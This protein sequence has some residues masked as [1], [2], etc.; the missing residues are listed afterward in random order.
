MLM[1]TNQKSWTVS[2]MNMRVGAAAGAALITQRPLMWKS[3]DTLTTG[4]GGASWKVV[5]SCNG[6]GGA[7]SFT[8][9][10]SPWSAT[11]SKWT[12]E[13]DLVWGSAGSN[14]S[15]IVLKN[16]ALGTANANVQLCIDLSNGVGSQLAT[17]MMSTGSGFTGGTATAR[18]TAADEFSLVSNTHW[19][20]Y[21]TNVDIDCYLNVAMSTDGECTRMWIQRNQT[22]GMFVLIDKPATPVSGWTNPCVAVWLGANTSP[23]YANLYSA[24]GAR[25]Y[26]VSAMNLFFTCEGRG[27]A[28]LGTVLVNANNLDGGYFIGQIGV[29]SET[30]SNVGRY[31]SLYD[32]W[33]LSTSIN[34]GD[35]LPHDINRSFVAVGNL[36]HPNS[37]ETQL[38][39]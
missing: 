31:G 27:A 7:G 19:G 24:A 17:M 36:L 9:P 32:L 25:G 15:W 2:H 10:A 35:H 26:G 29:V 21:T 4:F 34:N 1:P 23:S 11:T 28:A 22:C 5:G 16:S 33:W 20:A 12:A 8:S 6:T 3:V 30:L 37:G 39:G 14:H 38:L 18:P 13:A